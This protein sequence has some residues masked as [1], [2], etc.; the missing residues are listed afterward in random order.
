[1]NISTPNNGWPR[2]S[3]QEHII[4]YAHRMLLLCCKDILDQI[5]LVAV[6]DFQGVENK[7]TFTH[8]LS[9]S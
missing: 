1:M 2:G 6:L 3:K 8:A 4:D 7:D 9:L 5:G